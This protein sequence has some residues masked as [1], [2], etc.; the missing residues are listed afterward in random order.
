MSSSARNALL[1]VA[2]LALAVGAFLVLNP[3]DDDE[4]APTTATT[5]TATATD[6][7]TTTRTTTTTTVTP[8][9]V[10]L[11]VT[12]GGEPVGGVQKVEVSKGDSAEIDVTSDVDEQVHMHGYDIEESI[13]AGGRAKLRFKADIP[14]RFEIELHESGRQ[15]GELTVNP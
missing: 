5:V 13:P 2:A 7:G 9:A 6:T 4:S 14:G 11:I 8:P 15:I 1:V 12:R 3:G 10:K